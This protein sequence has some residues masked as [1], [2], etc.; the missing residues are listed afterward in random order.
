MLRN[1]WTDD[2]AQHG[3]R[4]LELQLRV[5]FSE[6]GGRAQ[7]GHGPATLQNDDSFARLLDTVEYCQAS[8]LEVSC[9]HLFHLTSMKDQS[10]DVNASAEQ[11]HNP[12][13]T[14]GAT[15]CTVRRVIGRPNP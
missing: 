5:L 3:N 6:P 1:G 4:A 13:L 11:V 12:R 8:G 7:F 15:L 14:P 9:V 10:G 2:V